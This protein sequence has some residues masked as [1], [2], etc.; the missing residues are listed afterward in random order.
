FKRFTTPEEVA[1]AS[2]R[3][4]GTFIKSV[5]LW[6]SK[7][8]NIKK[9]CAMLVRDSNSTVP[10]SMNDLIR[11]PGVGRKTAN[12]V[13][14]A[15]FQKNE[16]I[17]I[18]THNQRLAVRLGLTKEKNPKKIERGL[19]QQIPQKEWGLFSILL[20]HHGRAICTARNPQCAA[21]ILNKLCPSAFTFSRN[22][23]NT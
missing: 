12:V 19:M 14:H 15:G 22:V 11:L 17:A 9:A 18:D 1:S 7:A 6:T 21:C 23:K 10:A 20:V 13:L 2:V 8:R 5:G 16:G 4:I 3:E